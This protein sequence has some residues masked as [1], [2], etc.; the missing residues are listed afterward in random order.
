VAVASEFLKSGRADHGLAAAWPSDNNA[1]VSL[2][3]LADHAV[4]VV[5]QF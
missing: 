2:I 4:L 3:Q 5:T 1:L